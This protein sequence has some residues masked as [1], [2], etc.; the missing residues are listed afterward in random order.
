[1]AVLV[2]GQYFHHTWIVDD[3]LFFYLIIMDVG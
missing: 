3:K 1:M 2:C